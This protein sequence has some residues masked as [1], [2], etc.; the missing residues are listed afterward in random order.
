MFNPMGMVIGLALAQQRTADPLIPAIV[1]G[2][3]PM[4]LGIVASTLLVDRETQAATPLPTP[5][6]A[7]PVE[8]Q[9]EDA[10][11]AVESAQ[12]SGDAKAA[13]A[14]VR[15]LI[16]LVLGVSDADRPKLLDRLE[17]AGLLQ[18]VGPAMATP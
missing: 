6:T 2:A 8:Q 9:L 11:K 18:F 7:P 12:Q 10:I 3:L 13:L 17:A 5:P 16:D 4:P 15:A 14:A 1:A